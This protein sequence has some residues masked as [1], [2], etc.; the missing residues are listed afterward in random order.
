M[1]IATLIILSI[2]AGV[3]EA[4]VEVLLWRTPHTG[5][6]RP[7]WWGNPE[8]T[9]GRKY[10]EGTADSGPA[11]PMSTTLLVWVTDAYH[12][13]RTYTAWYPLG[14]GL[15]MWWGSL[16]WWWALIAVGI[17]IA[18]AGTLLKLRDL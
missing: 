14:L 5:S 17:Q 15:V 13:F 8:E 18:S 4:L 3:F 12:F 9:W 1:E 10:R 11:F 6:N 7:P 2:S 16:D